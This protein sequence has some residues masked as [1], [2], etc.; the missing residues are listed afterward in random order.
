MGAQLTPPN[1][2]TVPIEPKF[3]HTAEPKLYSP[4]SAMMVFPSII[5]AVLKKNGL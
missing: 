3:V 1:G 5:T 4:P 2:V